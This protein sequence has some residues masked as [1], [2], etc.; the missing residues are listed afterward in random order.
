MNLKVSYTYPDGPTLNGNIYSEEVLAA[1]FEEP[2][3]KD[4]RCLSL[5]KNSVSS[6]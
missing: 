1:A 2:A 3:F 5:L 4:C 6:S